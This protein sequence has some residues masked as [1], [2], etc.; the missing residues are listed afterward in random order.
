M[1]DIKFISK[2]LF[3]SVCRIWRIRCTLLSRR[4]ERC[5][6]IFTTP[7]HPSIRY[8]CIELSLLSTVLPLSKET[9]PSFCQNS[10]LHLFLS[11]TLVH[12]ITFK[13]VCFPLRLFFINA[14]IF[15]GFLNFTRLQGLRIARLY[16]SVYI[17]ASHSQCW[18]T[19]HTH[20]RTDTD[21]PNTV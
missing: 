7:E 16:P 13:A 4:D 3:F 17:H 19:S 1:I 18:L 6:R 21:T 20:A 5:W 9:P 12:G 14:P 11:V 10:T 2:P 8:I 15:L